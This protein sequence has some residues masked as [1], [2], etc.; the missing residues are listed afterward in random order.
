VPV[1]LRYK[2]YR[3]EC[4]ASDQDEPPHVHVKYQGRHAQFWLEPTVLLEFNVRFRPHELN[5][6]RRIV[7]GRRDELL[8]AWHGFFGDDN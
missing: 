2:G 6:V 7:E 3:F 8:E 5:E 4:Y 1:I